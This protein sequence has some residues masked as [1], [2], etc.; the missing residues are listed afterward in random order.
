MYHSSWSVRSCQVGQITSISVSFLL[1]QFWSSFSSSTLLFVTSFSS[2]LCLLDSEV[3]NSFSRCQGKAWGVT[4]WPKKVFLY[5]YGT[6]EKKNRPDEEKAGWFGKGWN[7]I[8]CWWII[9]LLSF[10]NHTLFPKQ[11]TPGLLQWSSFQAHS[12]EVHHCSSQFI[13]QASH[14]VFLL[15]CCFPLAAFFWG[16]H[17][18]LV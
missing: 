9:S 1:V 14:V 18:A 12:Q 11:F 4:Q 17:F 6:K 5:G 8:E 10:C 3:L 7:L 15:R 2:N 16:C 13:C